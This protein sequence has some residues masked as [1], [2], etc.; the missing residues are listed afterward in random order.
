MTKRRR[1]IKTRIKAWIRSQDEA[2]SE[3]YRN[4]QSPGP[5]ASESKWKPSSLQ[6]REGLSRRS[7]LCYLGAIQRSSYQER[8]QSRGPARTEASRLNGYLH[9][10]G[11]AETAEFECGIRVETDKH[12]LFTCVR[13]YTERREQRARWPDKIWDLSFFQGGRRRGE[14]ERGWRPE[15]VAIRA[16]A[17]Y[18]RATARLVTEVV[19]EGTL[20]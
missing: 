6:T 11:A 18:A 20:A 19:E 13:L 17:A 4:R 1:E 12:Y 14:E 7:T 5:Y 10:I 15:I 3:Y 16:I 2:S 9:A 8:S